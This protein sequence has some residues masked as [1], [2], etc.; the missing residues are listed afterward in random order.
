[1]SE[2]ED[3]TDTEFDL[4]ELDVLDSLDMSEEL[5]AL[6]RLQ[7]IICS[8][9]RGCH[10]RCQELCYI[11]GCPHLVTDVVIALIDRV[12]QLFTYLNFSLIRTFRLSEQI[13]VAIGHRGSDK[14]GSTV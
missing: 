1:M 5:L 12:H 11:C 3:I 10:G 6:S 2:I 9:R 8:V 13:M 4:G 14:Q 7:W